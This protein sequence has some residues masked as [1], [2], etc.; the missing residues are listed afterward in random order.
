MKF[1]RHLLVSI[2]N[3]LENMDRHFLMY[4]QNKLNCS[5]IV[6]VNSIIQVFALRMQASVL[7]EVSVA[8][9][10]AYIKWDSSREND[11]SLLYL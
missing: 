3:K 5:N 2:Q 1:D 10:Q 9:Y 8:D 4:C 7:L 11:N 6:R